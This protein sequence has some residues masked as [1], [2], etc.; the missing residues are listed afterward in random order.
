MTWHNQIDFDQCDL[1]VTTG[2]QHQAMTP[3]LTNTYDSELREKAGMHTPPPPPECMGLEGEYD[4]YGLVRRVAEALDHDPTLKAVDT[5]TLSQ[6][7]ST[8]ALAGQVS[9]RTLLERVVAIASA[10]DGT[11]AVDS[12]HITVGN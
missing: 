6:H 5:V 11:R 4:D 8:V 2:A 7:G 3:G 12:T 10:V 9:D 1:A